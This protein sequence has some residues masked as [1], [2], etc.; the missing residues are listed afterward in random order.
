MASYQPKGS[1][2]AACQHAARDCS[3]LTFG[4]MQV[5]QRYP[6]GTLAV[7]CSSFESAKTQNVTC[8]ERGGRWLDT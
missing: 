8:H 4:Q 7:K 6:D 2:C 3:A 5:V 1:M